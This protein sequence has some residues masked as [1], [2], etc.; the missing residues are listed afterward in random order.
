MG[1]SLSSEDP[2]KGGE[3]LCDWEASFLVRTNDLVHSFLKIIEKKKPSTEIL[4]TTL[5][6]LMASFAAHSCCGEAGD[7]GKRECLETMLVHVR[8]LFE[9]YLAMHPPPL[10]PAGIPPS[11]VEPGRP[12]ETLK[13]SP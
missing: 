10:T 8:N 12:V 11:C 4:Y 7:Q 2:S 13:H 9:Q 6:Q 5:C 1:T 3:S